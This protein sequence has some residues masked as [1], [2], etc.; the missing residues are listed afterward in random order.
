MYYPP[1]FDLKKAIELGELVKLAYQQLEFFRDPDAYKLTY[2]SEWKLPPEYTLV[3]IITYNKRQLSYDVVNGTEE[4]TFIDDE[5]DE[6]NQAKSGIEITGASQA[7]SVSFGIMDDVASE[8]KDWITNK[9]YPMGF[10]AKDEKNV[11]LIFRGTVMKQEF[12]KDA[13]IVFEPY[14][15]R[16]D[17]GKVAVGFLEVYNACRASFIDELK[18]LDASLNLF[19]SGHSL[20]AALSVLALPDVVKATQFKKPTLYNF[21]CPR[22]G[23]NNFVTAYNALPGQKT[24]RIVNSSDLVP[25]VPPPAIPIPAPGYYYSHVDVPVEFNVQFNDVGK[26]HSM[27]TY[28]DVLSK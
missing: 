18:K 13:K 9:D 20:G 8:I 16:T 2:H 25:S 28:L 15:L 10:I 24:F 27:V 21:G 11:Y 14:L 5:I 22:V 26:N 23:D 1:K 7:Q 3:S 19:I 12:L 6:I 17:W 4:K